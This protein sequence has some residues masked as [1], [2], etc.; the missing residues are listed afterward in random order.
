MFVIIH[1]SATIWECIYVIRRHLSIVRVGASLSLF[2]CFCLFLWGL[3]PEN[4]NHCMC[5][6]NMSYH[7]SYHT[8]QTCWSTV[9]FVKA[10]WLRIHTKVWH[11]SSPAEQ[12]NTWPEDTSPTVDVESCRTTFSICFSF[13]VV[14]ITLA[15]PLIGLISPSSS[16]AGQLT[17]R[18]A[19]IGGC[20][21][22]E[23]EFV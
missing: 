8:P 15:W 16:L 3:K 10:T 5:E 6:I 1:L 20:T 17:K 13:G 22:E 11:S 2:C 21:A 4:F 18:R 7:V 23:E 12:E 14:V 9:C 19:T